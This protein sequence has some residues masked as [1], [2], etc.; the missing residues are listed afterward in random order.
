MESAGSDWYK[1]GWTLDIQAQSWVED[2][3][4]QVDFIVRTLGL[5]GR[6]RILDL[7]C[8]FGRHA[9]ELARRGFPVVGVDITGAY[10]G[11]AT[12]R[13]EE[14]GLSARFFCSDIRD[15]KPEQTFD[16]VL[17]LSDGAIGYLEDE[18]ENLKIFDVISRALRPGGKHFMDVMNAGYADTHFPCQLWDAGEQGLTLSRFEW[19]AKTRVMLYGQWDRR[20]GEALDRPAITRGNPTRLYHLAEI[21]DIL[22]RRDM[23]IVDTFSD[24][25]G[26]PLSDGAIQMIVS[27]QKRG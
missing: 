5:T 15:F 3:R 12:R 18:G 17:S 4:R 14:E 9:L 26:S 11:H 27:S 16:A 8:G 6:A 24:Y 23:H 22:H 7:A 10:I 19:D 25:G 1:K 21:R 20:Y 13:A 2:T